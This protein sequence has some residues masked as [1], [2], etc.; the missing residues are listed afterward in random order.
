MRSHK[1]ADHTH[2][3]YDDEG[4]HVLSH[5]KRSICHGYTAAQGNVQRLVDL[6]AKS[7]AATTD[8]RT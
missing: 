2:S 3:Y 4:T 7:K 5:R 8:W 6:E 1:G